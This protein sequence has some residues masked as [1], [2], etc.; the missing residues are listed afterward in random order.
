MAN[1]KIMFT[2]GTMGDGGAERVVSVLA[3][4][5][6]ING[7]DVLITQ[8]YNNKSDY[9]LRDGI[10]LINI[11]PMNNNLR[12][13]MIIKKL[14]EKIKFEKPDIIISFLSNINIYTILASR[15]LKIPVI[16]SERNDPHKEPSKIYL[17]VL[18]AL[19][20]NF[21]DGLVFQ[22]KGAQEYFSKN[23]QEKSRIIF[24]PLVD[25]LPELYN[26]KRSRNI[27]TVCRLSRQKNLKLLID[28]FEIFYKK[29]QGFKL[30][31][32]GEGEQRKELENYIK[33]LKAAD[34]ILLPGFVTD[35]H[36]RIRESSMFILSSDYE[37]LPN[38][39]LEA[40]AMGM[41]SISTDCPIGGPREF[42][43]TKKNGILVPVSGI[44][45]LV[46]AMEYIIYDIERSNNMG[47][48]ASKI[49]STLSADKIV[50]S[51][52]KLIET[53]VK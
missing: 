19:L 53:V 23:L 47:K 18:R 48:E 22:T 3:N 33:K 38:A 34:R 27:V 24:N 32:Y 4:Q 9:E 17:K 1:Y 2:I 13:V 42:I 39:L 45:E 52:L 46:D 41:P 49:R 14:R 6:K 30:I 43:K 7:H 5:F 40:M 29:N 12:S 10:K 8:L 37:G 44:N 16:I 28:A 15:G 25:G 50:S 51:W 26:G 20:Y 36:V 31:I 21:A 11:A 35:V